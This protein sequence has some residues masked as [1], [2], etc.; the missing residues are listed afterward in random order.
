MI[1]NIEQIDEIL[2]TNS[3]IF[4]LR[5][6][7]QNGTDLLQSLPHFMNPKEQSKIIDII[8]KNERDNGKNNTLDN[9]L[10]LQPFSLPIIDAFI[11]SSYL[12]KKVILYRVDRILQISQNIL[13]TLQVQKRKIRKN[14]KGTI[15]IE[16]SEA[17]L[18]DIIKEFK[19]HKE[20]LKKKQAIQAK[21]KRQKDE[22]FIIDHPSLLTILR[23]FIKDIPR[24]WSIGSKLVAKKITDWAT[25]CFNYWQDHKSAIGAAIKK[26]FGGLG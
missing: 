13:K 2:N 16:S 7:T 25:C 26:F 10:L 17:Q 12:E 18:N 19:K 1:L 15:S 5:L 3:E 24:K 22:I 9:L 14:E 4:L 20:I 8:K 21:V 23:I 6:R 11:N